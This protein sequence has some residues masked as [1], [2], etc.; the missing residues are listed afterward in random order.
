MGIMIVRQLHKVTRHYFPDLFERMRQLPDGRKRKDYDVAELITGCLSLF[1]F[2]ETTRNAFNNDRKGNKFRDNYFK[3]FK[4][5]LPHMDTVEH[6]LRLLSPEELEHLKAAL[7]SSLIEQRVLHRFKF[8]GKYFT[9][10]ID[11]TGTNSYRENDQEASRLKKTSKNGITTYMYHVVEAKLI[12]SSGLAISLGSEWVQNLGDRNFDKQDCEKRAFERLAKKIKRFF[13]RLPICILADGLYPNKTFMETCRDNGWSFIVVLKDDTLKTLQEDIEDV[14]N[15]KRRSL[16]SNHREAKGKTHIT[17]LYN[18]IDETLTY[19]GHIIYWVSCTETVVHY[20]KDGVQKEA[21]PAPTKFVFITSQKAGDKN[22]RCICQAGRM[23]W[24]IEN[25]GFNTQKNGGYNLGHK[26]SRKSFSSYKNYY[27]CMQIAHT[28]NMLIEQSSNIAALLKND[29]K[30]TVKH[31][32]KQL[33]GVLAYTVI[34]EVDF[35][36]EQRYQI[37][38]AG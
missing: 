37:R 23:R 36:T 15:K 28:I 7:V 31:I 16:E 10:A 4:L 21:Q 33:I 30:L 25:Q 5:R 14:E 29:T 38:L 3:V 12:T 18:W 2:K 13:P 9:V 26:F 19:A 6:F 32:W 11:G 20:D 22:V 34:N 24:T 8:L 27:Q 17:T 35:A 1:V